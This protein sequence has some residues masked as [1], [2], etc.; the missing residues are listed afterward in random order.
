MDLSIS[1]VSYNQLTNLSKCI[2]SLQTHIEGISYEVI[3]VAYRFTP[4]NLVSLRDTFPEIIIIESNEIRGF[5]ENYNLALK[6]A[7]GTY[8]LVLN[9][10]AFF[11]DSTVMTLM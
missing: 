7:R 2:A 6:S 10:D 4:Q 3:V 9:D 11:L 1:I 5:S 8:C